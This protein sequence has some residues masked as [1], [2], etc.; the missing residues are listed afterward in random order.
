MLKR[1]ITLLGLTITIG[2]L[3]LALGCG[4]SN[5]NPVAPVS[6]DRPLVSRGNLLPSKPWVSIG[7]NIWGEKFV[8]FRAIDNDGDR[9][10]YRVILRNGG[11]FVFDQTVD[12]SGF[13]KPDYASG[14]WG[15]FKVPKNGLPAGFYQVYVQAHD[16]TDW[17]PTNN[18]PRYIT[19]P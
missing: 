6:S 14:E 8:L 11:D 15:A 13:S 1:T 5:S 12:P 16:G 9:L 4:G 17:G 3:L 18:P 2:A 7:M 19:L 10:K